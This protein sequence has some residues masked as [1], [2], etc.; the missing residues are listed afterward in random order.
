MVNKK[1]KELLC[2]LVNSR[3]ELCH[4]AY[5]KN[6]L[7]IHRI[8]RGSVGGLYEHRNCKVL[9]RKCHGLIHSGEFK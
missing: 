5:T 7:H 9:C 8:R 4:I 1:F 2:E 6:N 3:C